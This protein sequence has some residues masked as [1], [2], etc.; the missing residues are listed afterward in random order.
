MFKIEEAATKV[1]HSVI[2]APWKWTQKDQEM[3]DTHPDT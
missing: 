2:P 3:K 1:T